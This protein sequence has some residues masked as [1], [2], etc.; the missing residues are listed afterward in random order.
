MQSAVATFSYPFAMTVCLPNSGTSVLRRIELQSL[1]TQ[2]G[3]LAS[4]GDCEL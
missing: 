2:Q 3:K 1:Y 4:A